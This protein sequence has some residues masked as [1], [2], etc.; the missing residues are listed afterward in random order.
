[1]AEKTPKANPFEQ[2]MAQAT[3]M[4]TKLIET[5]FKTVTELHAEWSKAS[6]EASR[7]AMELFAR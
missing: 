1:M 7:K 3:E 2:W 6:L 5:S 4:Q